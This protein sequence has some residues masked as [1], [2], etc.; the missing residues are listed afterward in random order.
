MSDKPLKWLIER[1]DSGDLVLPEIQRD[2][3]WKRDNVRQLFD[4]LYRKLPIGYMLVWKAKK[5]IP[6]KEFKNTKKARIGQRVN[7]FYGYLLDGQ[8][9]LTA[10]RLIRDRHDDYP[11]LFSLLPSNNKEPDQN[12]FVY[13]NYGKE[14]KWYVPVADI[15]SEVCSPWEL[16]QNLQSS[17]KIGAKEAQSIHNDLNR[18]KDILLYSVGVIEFE[19]DDIRTATQLFIRFNS[20]GRKLNRSDLVAAELA[21]TA[22]ELISKPISRLSTAYSPHFNFTK[23]YLIQ[24]LAAKLTDRIDPKK[25]DIWHDYTVKQIHNSWAKTKMGVDKCMKFITGTMRWDSD[26]WL[27]S[28]NAIMPLIYI[29]SNK[30][31]SDGDT[32]LARKWLVLSCIY[33]LFS[34]SVHTELDRII[35]GL[36][37]DPSIRKLYAIT[38]G[39]LGRIENDHFQTGRRSGPAMSLFIT[40][41]RSNNAKDW[42][43]HDDSLDGTVIGHNAELQI[44]HFFPRE[45]LSNHGI[46]DLD[47][48]NTFAN[49]TVISKDTNLKFLDSEPIEY[50]AKNNVKKRDLEAQFIPLDEELWRVCNYRK[51]LRA[52]RDL[53]VKAA[54][55]FLG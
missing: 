51:F 36:S 44:H 28:V 22:S 54:N 12:R 1:I 38:R 42:L 8:Q 23:T 39:S 45:C 55:Q 6:H 5:F 27:P 46:D 17:E 18:L 19:H 11:L 30:S 24:C 25:I 15:L 35:K 13:G 53:L 33:A 21:L 40:L 10:I 14:K 26:S 20:T 37:K 41:I 2:F 49:Y 31:F 50:I 16:A 29:L 47:L 3:V 43:S 52:R 9:R 32:K 34:G 4:S 48:I 7:D